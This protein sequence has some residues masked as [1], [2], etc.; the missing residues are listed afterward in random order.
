MYIS[1]PL[2]SLDTPEEGIRSHTDGHEPPCGCW[3]LNSESLEEQLALSTTQPSF[4]PPTLKFYLFSCFLFCCFG[5]VLL[6]FFVCFVLL[7]CFGFWF[8]REGFSVQ[9]SLGYPRPQS[10]DQVDL[11]L[12]GIPLPLPSK[13][14][15]QGSF[16][17][18]IH[19]PLRSFVVVLVVFRDRVSL[20]SPS[21]PG[22]H[23]VD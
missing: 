17:S 22:T 11:E 12:T 2:F 18:I 10:V 14:S 7:F 20:Y 1:T 19:Y 21:C 5:F 13:Y 3:E 8:L 4:Q 9:C 23:F 15:I 6:G 16:I